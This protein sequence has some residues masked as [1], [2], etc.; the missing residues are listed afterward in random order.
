MHMRVTWLM[1]VG[2]K[3]L[4]TC[5]N[6]I[7][8][9]IHLSSASVHMCDMSSQCA[10]DVTRA[11]VCE[12][13]YSYVRIF[14][15]LRSIWATHLCM[16][17]TWLI[18]MCVHDLFVCTRR[19]SCVCVCG[20]LF[21]VRIY[22]SP[23]S[24]LSARPYVCE[25]YDWFI[26]TWH[27]SFICVWRDSFICLWHDPILCACVTRSYVCNVTHSYVCEMT[28]SY[29]SDTYIAIFISTCVYI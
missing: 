19:D 29:M 25:R 9:H 23:T 16:C 20:Y 2:V 27:D 11:C 28:R 12:M 17:A 10:R 7:L 13:T 15:C 6:I 1:Y 5:A 18:S 4:N 21:I 26:W 14:F 8:A 22:P 24:I 3:W